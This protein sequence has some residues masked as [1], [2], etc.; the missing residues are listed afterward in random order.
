MKPFVILSLLIALM[1]A[2]CSNHY[3]R[4]ENE[5]T[6]LF[7]KTRHAQSVMFAS[8]LDHFQWRSAA[9]INDRTWQITIPGDIPQTYIYLVDNQLFLPECRFK[10]KD[11]FGSE[12]CIYL[13]GM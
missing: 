6:H 9:R 3:L 2:A 11:D 12:N 8:S 4:T 10:E 13:P 7:L 5:Q 1:L